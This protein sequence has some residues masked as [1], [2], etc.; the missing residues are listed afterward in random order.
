MIW[1]L[2]W[3]VLVLAAAV[4]LGLLGLRLWRQTRA[5]A[6]ELRTAG[7]RFTEVADRLADLEQSP[8]DGHVEP[9]DVRSPV[10]RQRP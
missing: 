7:D 6:F 5:L 1:V 2:V 10:S 9:P 8:K 3:A 4:L